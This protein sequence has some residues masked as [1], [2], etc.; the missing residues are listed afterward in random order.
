[1]LLGTDDGVNQYIYFTT[2]NTAAY[3]YGIFD[4][5]ILE[6]LNCKHYTQEVHLSLTHSH[7][8]EYME[9]CSFFAKLI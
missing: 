5:N 2:V 8:E 1:M 6:L 3:F 4:S 7:I 9:V